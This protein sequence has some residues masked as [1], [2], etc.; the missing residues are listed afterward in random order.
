MKSSLFHS[1][2]QVSSGTEMLSWTTGA[3]GQVPISGLNSMFE[4]SWNDLPFFTQ[5][6][7]CQLESMV[8]PILSPYT[9]DTFMALNLSLK[10]AQSARGEPLIAITLLT[11]FLVFG[12]TARIPAEAAPASGPKRVIL[13][14]SPW[15][16]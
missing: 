16:A 8:Q 12:I 9:L 14:L 3:Q 10:T 13:S 5:S 2:F 1:T 6:T 7:N 15:K 4:S 11:M